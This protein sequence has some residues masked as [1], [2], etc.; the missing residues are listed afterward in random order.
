[1]QMGVGLLMWAVVV[2]ASRERS[3]L[4]QVSEGTCISVPLHRNLEEADGLSGPT[5]LDSGGAVMKTAT[6]VVTLPLQ[7]GIQ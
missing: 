2:P 6:H 5:P 7:V 3:V 1:M 4:E